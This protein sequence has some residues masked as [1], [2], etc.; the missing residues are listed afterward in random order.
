MCDNFRPV[1]N[2]RTASC[3]PSQAKN[4]W[5]I[6]KAIKQAKP[7][8]LVNKTL[9][10]TTC[11]QLC[12]DSVTQCITLFSFFFSKNFTF[13]STFKRR[14]REIFWYLPNFFFA[15]FESNRKLK[16]SYVTPEQW[17]NLE[18]KILGWM[19]RSFRRRKSLYGYLTNELLLQATTISHLTAIKF[20]L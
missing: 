7:V 5:W 1:Q 6:I 20:Y 10:E 4:S 17:P 15:T 18:S 16:G 8:V 11:P 13:S 12:P 14:K 2:L 3:T 19:E 9:S